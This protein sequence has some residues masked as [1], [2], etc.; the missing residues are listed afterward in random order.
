MVRISDTCSSGPIAAR[1]ALTR[2]NASTAL[3][4]GTRYSVCNSSPKL[5]V[6]SRRKCGRRSCHGPGIPH[7]SVQQSAGYSGSGWIWVC[8]R[9][10]P[11]HS[12]AN[13]CSVVSFR[14]LR[15]SWQSGPSRHVVNAL[16]LYELENNSSKFEHSVL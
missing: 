15:N 14:R 2:C 11:S 1:S 9:R 5:G 12:S 7:C 4:R 16:T 6:K 8:W 10:A 3:D 13:S